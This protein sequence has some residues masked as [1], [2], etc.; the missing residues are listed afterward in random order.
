MLKNLE[1]Y[2]FQIHARD[3]NRYI[4]QFENFVSII[5][6]SVNRM[7]NLAPTEVSQKDVPYLISLCNNVPPQRPKFNV[8]DRVRIRKKIETFHRGFSI[9]FTEELF[10]ISHIPTKN[11]LTYVVK[12]VNDEIVQGQFFEP[13]LVKFVT[14]N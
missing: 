2:Q 6:D 11:P 12:D 13:E 1:N 7:T 8:G 3:T 14:T 5:T 9:Q 10:T 4:D